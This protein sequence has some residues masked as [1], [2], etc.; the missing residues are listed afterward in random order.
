[1]GTLKSGGTEIR[2][3]RNK[4]GTKIRGRLNKATPK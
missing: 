3:L 2:G 1:M 4:G